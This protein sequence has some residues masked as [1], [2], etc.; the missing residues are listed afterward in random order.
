MNNIK[1]EKL[2]VK[3]LNNNKTEDQTVDVLYQRM[4]DRWYAFSLVGDDVYAGAVTEE[5]IDLEIIPT[6]QPI[7]VD[8]A[9]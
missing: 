3:N 1:K 9:S 2:T 8:M 7:D 4:G 6:D 5:N